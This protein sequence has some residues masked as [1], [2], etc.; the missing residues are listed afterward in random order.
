MSSDTSKRAMDQPD[1]ER[2]TYDLEK[3]L[4][5]MDNFIK[6]LEANRVGVV[7][8]NRDFI[9][10]RSFWDELIDVN[11]TPQGQDLHTRHSGPWDSLMEVWQL[12][13]AYLSDAMSYEQEQT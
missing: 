12:V 1:T 3:E 10:K 6:R 4:E 8:L 13:G 11:C 5:A 9:P 2:G 7:Q